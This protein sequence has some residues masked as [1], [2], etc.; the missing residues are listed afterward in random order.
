MNNDSNSLKA[1]IHWNFSFRAFHE[2]QFQGHFVKLEILSWN[3]FT[4]ESKFHC[5]CFSSIKKCVC[6]EKVSSDTDNLIALVL[7]NNICYS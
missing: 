1:K 4:L 7:I 6:R 2:I 3:T 5:V